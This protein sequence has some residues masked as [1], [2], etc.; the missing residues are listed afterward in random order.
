MSRENDSFL[1][2]VRD[3]LQ[4]LG[5]VEGRRMFSGYGLYL[6]DAFFGIVH[7]GRLYFKTDDA[8]RDAYRERG[9]GPFQPNAKQT[10]AS[11]YEVP[12]EVLEDGETLTEW[13]RRA[14]AARSGAKRRTPKRK[15]A[16]RGQAGRR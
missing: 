4:A 8:S 10:L 14:A 15:R 6:R 12:P 2:F 9:M 16:K 13:A 1:E 11:Y 5:G 7:D 3:Q